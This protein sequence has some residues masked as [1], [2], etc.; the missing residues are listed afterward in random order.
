MSRRTYLTDFYKFLQKITA[1][2]T[3]ADREEILKTLERELRRWL[4]DLEESRD[5]NPGGD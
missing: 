2:T 4:Y 5:D 1:N 3:G